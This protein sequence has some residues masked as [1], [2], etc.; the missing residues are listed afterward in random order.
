MKKD[1]GVSKKYKEMFHKIKYLINV[2]NNMI[3]M[4][5]T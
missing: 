5:N 1:K 2:K 4:I 3:I